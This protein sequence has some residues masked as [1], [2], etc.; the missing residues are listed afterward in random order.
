M[1]PKYVFALFGEFSEIRLDGMPLPQMS[2]RLFGKKYLIDAL[3]NLPTCLYQLP[4]IIWSLSPIKICGVKY[5]RL[6]RETRTNGQRVLAELN[7]QFQNT[8]LILLFSDNSTLA[9][10][11]RLQP[12]F[13]CTYIQLFFSNFRNYH[14]GKP[15]NC[16][17]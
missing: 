13:S 7:I 16:K 4:N 17:C 10:F 14:L 3:K 12:N 2:F 5:Q 8:R 1:T 11:A 15:R 9:R 6:W